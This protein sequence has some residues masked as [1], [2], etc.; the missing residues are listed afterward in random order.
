MYS[1]APS[2]IS[3][4]FDLGLITDEVMSKGVGD[5]PSIYR[6]IALCIPLL[7]FRHNLLYS[8]AAT[9]PSSMKKGAI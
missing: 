7:M 8:F 9:I 3:A 5:S 2:I 4:L 1:R 6:P